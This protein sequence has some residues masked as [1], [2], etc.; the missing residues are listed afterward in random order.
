MCQWC[1]GLLSVSAFLML[2]AGC[3]TVTPAP[4]ADKVRVTDKAGDVT[5]C[6]AVGN[7][8]LSNDAANNAP[9]TQFQNA[10]IESRW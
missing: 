4:G 10:V 7:V 1:K 8:H 9:V 5:G 6:A 3:A 2:L